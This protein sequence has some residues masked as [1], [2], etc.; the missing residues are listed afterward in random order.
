[1]GEQLE[2]EAFISIAGQLRD[3][4]TCRRSSNG[5]SC[6]DCN[7]PLNPGFGFASGYGCG[8]YRYCVTHGYFDF[9]P[10]EEPSEEQASDVQPK[11][12]PQPVTVNWDEDD[13]SL[14]VHD[15]N[16]WEIIK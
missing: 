13:L 3:P 7:G 15:P 5:K 8:F 16:K 2:M 11:K 10:E 12:A 6:P 4:A 1:M 14:P 9:V